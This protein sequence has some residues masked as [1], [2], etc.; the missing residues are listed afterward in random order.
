MLA[1]LLSATALASAAPAAQDFPAGV[2]SSWLEI[3][4]DAERRAFI[5]P[6]PAG[7]DGAR[8]RVR[9][10]F[11]FSNPAKSGAHRLDYENEIDCERNSWRIVT[12]AAYAPNGRVVSEGRFPAGEG[13]EAIPPGSQ[14]EAF[15]ARFCGDGG[16]AGIDT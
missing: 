13:F 6:R 2:E 5:D 10:R 9:G 12:M 7:R 8:V 3:G 1:L 15:A 14:A 16:G 4:S 11:I